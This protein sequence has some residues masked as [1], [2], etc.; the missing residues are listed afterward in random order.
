MRKTIK[1]EALS[2]VCYRPCAAAVEAAGVRC[3][4]SNRSAAAALL[5]DHPL[6]P[7][8]C[9]V[10]DDCERAGTGTAAP[11]DGTA[12]AD[13]PGSVWSGLRGGE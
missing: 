2:L 7:P 3:A 11:D 10:G 5:F 9:R 8:K 6:V 1:R 4:A 12:D 13:I